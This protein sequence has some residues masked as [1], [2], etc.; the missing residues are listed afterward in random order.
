MAITA[1]YLEISNDLERK[2]V[3][4]ELQ[5]RLP[6]V[7]RL[8][9]IYHAGQSTVKRA[10]AELTK[11][12]MVTCDSTRGTF[13]T[14]KRR[15]DNH[16]GVICLVGVIFDEPQNSSFVAALNRI[17]ATRGYSIL[18]VADITTFSQLR[19]SA[20]ADLPCDGYLIVGL[21]SELTASLRRS[22]KSVVALN[23][24]E[25]IIDGVSWVDFDWQSVYSKLF[26]HFR[27][28][29]Y[30]RIALATYDNRKFNFR[31][32][33]FNYYLKNVGDDFNPDY[34]YGRLDEVQLH[35]KFGHNYREQGGRL[36][37][38]YYAALAEEPE[39]LVLHLSHEYIK[40]FRMHWQDITDK[41]VPELFCVSKEDIAGENML[42]CD[43][44]DLYYQALQLLFDDL[45]NDGYSQAKNS[46]SRVRYHFN[47]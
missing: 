10:I 46:L 32:K 13:I 3:N 15:P 25:G 47:S 14:G 31:D 19:P 37:A 18:Q 42:I 27:Q 11:K 12:G 5:G 33:L 26:Q 23:C 7:I 16:Y 21:T 17:A 41:P 4:G 8:T 2:I 20:L 44:H 35:E 6:G 28:K 30:R 43:Y 38:E 29:H 40:A 39:A 24:C 22:G 36:L 9:D 1:R 34:F 45:N